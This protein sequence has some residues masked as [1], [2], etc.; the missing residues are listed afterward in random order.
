MLCDSESGSGALHKQACEPAL[1]CR[2]PSLVAFPYVP[3]IRQW[4][5][6]TLLCYLAPL[7]RPLCP[8]SRTVHVTGGSRYAHLIRQSI[9]EKGPD[10]R[11]NR[12]NK[13]SEKRCRI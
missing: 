13:P 8:I 6:G 5:S 3:T 1:P 9:P 4:L 7:A 11:P 12:H 10:L 2:I